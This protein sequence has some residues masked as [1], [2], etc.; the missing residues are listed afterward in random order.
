MKKES[1]FTLIELLLVI[2]IITIL[3]GIAVADLMEAQVRSKISRG[4]CDMRSLATA[5]ECYRVD[6]NARPASLDNVTSPIAYISKIP[7]DPF[8]ADE[9]QP[10]VYKWIDGSNWKLY[11]VGPDKSM[12]TYGLYEVTNGSSAFPFHYVDT[13]WAQ[14]L[15]D[16]FGKYSPTYDVTNG[17]SHTFDR[18][19]A[20]KNG[21]ISYG[22]IVY[23]ID[24]PSPYIEK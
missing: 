17:T 7:V 3:A 9:Q 22:D 10:Y 8:L 15:D 18:I 19:Y 23:P 21:T 2:A 6:N 5:I 1:A 16:L 24:S 11:C 12:S 20:P 13:V 14:H 4:L